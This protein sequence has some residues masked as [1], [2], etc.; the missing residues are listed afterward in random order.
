M[1]VV[2]FSA[3]NALFYILIAIGFWKAKKE[4]KIAT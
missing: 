4:L 3:L 1:T 2:Y